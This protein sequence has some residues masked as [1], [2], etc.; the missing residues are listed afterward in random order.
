MTRGFD[1]FFG[2]RLN[3][4]LS[5]PSRRRLFE[6]PSLSLCRH[7]ND[8]KNTWRTSTENGQWSWCK[9]FRRLLYRRL[10]LWQLPVP[11][12]STKLASWLSFHCVHTLGAIVVKLHPGAGWSYTYF[13]PSLSIYIGSCCLHTQTN[14][15]CMSRKTHNSHFPIS[16]WWFSFCAQKSPVSFAAQRVG[17][18]DIMFHGCVL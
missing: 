8:W 2:L 16:T 15:C 1:A 14:N 4:R 5:K 18:G 12:A 17:A 9:L 6:T 10:S 3:K 11:P 7:C 13:S